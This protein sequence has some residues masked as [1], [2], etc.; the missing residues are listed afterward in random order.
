MRE[1]KEYKIVNQWSIACDSYLTN[2]NIHGIDVD[3]LANQMMHD[4]EVAKKGMV[5]EEPKNDYKYILIRR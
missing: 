5:K 3:A 2:L 1:E 4:V